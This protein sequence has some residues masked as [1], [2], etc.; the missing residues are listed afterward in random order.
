MVPLA[1]PA[2]LAISS[3]EVFLN[4]RRE[5]ARA[6]S[7]RMDSFFASS[8][9]CLNH[10]FAQRSQV[11]LREASR[12]IRAHRSEAVEVPH[13]ARPAFAAAPLPRRAALRAAAGGHG[14]RGG[15]PVL[16]LPRPVRTDGRCAS[17]V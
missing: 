8:M 14:W 6:A 4:P 17:C 2:A 7:T 13:P 12:G 16:V 10:R 5:N 3:T 15:T 1:T 11:A 9:R